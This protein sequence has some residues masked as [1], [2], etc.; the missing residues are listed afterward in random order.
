MHLELSTDW[1]EINIGR[2]KTLYA[3]DTL[4][5]TFACGL[6]TRRNFGSLHT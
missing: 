2:L 6:A 5:L 1:N 4:K 3:Q